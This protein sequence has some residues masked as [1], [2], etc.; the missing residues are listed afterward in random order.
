MK[1]GTSC[2]VVL[3]LSVGGGWAA[4]Q[5]PDDFYRA[6]PGVTLPRVM[7]EVRPTYAPDAM[8]E[9]V[10]GRV[11]VECI[12]E[13]DGVPSHIRIATPLH[14]SL[15]AEA[16]K[17][18]AEWRFQPGTKDGKPARVQITVEMTFSMAPSSGPPQNVAIMRRASA[19]GVTTIWDVTRER[20]DRQPSWRPDAGTPPPF[21]LADA[22]QA[23]N[24][25]VQKL[26]A[27][28][29]PALMQSVSLLRL[30][31]LQWYYRVDYAPQ[32]ATPANASERVTVVVLLDGTVVEPRTER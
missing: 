3:L 32:T 15:D 19:D 29:N 1:C 17:A 20:F 23:S 13:L 30:N 21:S 28:S 16:A 18:M 2:L 9:Q 14:P 24:E 26:D 6:G 22:L 8:R 5:E 27:R 11:A 25:W 7:R 4:A 31:G 10:T 12:V